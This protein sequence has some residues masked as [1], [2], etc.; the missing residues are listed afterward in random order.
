[1]SLYSQ[2]ITTKL[3]TAEYL[4]FAAISKLVAALT[5][6]PYQVNYIERYYDVNRSFQVV[7]ARLQDQQNKYSGS[8]DCI[9]KILKL[10]GV[11]GF[12]KGLSPNL[13]RVVPATMITFVVYENISFYLLKRTEEQQKVVGI[14]NLEEGKA[15]KS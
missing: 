6:Y 8:L 10:E 3:G 12:Y 9:S 14:V 5:T 7:R 15:G 11:K 4:T 1:M 2:P 13:L